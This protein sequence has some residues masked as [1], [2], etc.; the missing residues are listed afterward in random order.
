M[1]DALEGVG[2]VDQAVG[3]EVLKEHKPMVIV[4]NKW[5]LALEALKAGRLED[6]DDE[7]SFREAFNQAARAKLFFAA[8]SPFVYVSALTGY[9]IQAM[10]RTARELDG[11]LD[12]VMPT[13]RL[14]Q[15]IKKLTE[16]RPPP[17]VDKRRFKIFYAVQTGHRPFRIRLFCNQPHRLPESYRRYLESGLVD[18]F[19]VDGCPIVFDLVGKDKRY[20]D[21]H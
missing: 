9:S 18:A 11:R 21:K 19:G 1:L 4:V 16:R 10:L 8:G 3:G 15:V 7:K 2:R 20:Q 17:R 5:D 13:G 12:T 14:N 6:Y